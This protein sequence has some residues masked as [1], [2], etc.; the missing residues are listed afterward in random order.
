[1]PNAVSKPNLAKEETLASLLRRPE[2]ADRFKQVLG[3]RAGEF[4]SSVLSVGMSMPDV[5]PI[6]ILQS[7]MKAAALD[8]P[9]EKSLG[10]AWIVPYSDHGNKVAQFQI[11]WKGLVQ[12]ALRTAAYS[13]MN[14]RPINA[15]AFGGYDDIGEP[16]ILWN[17]VDETEP[18]IGYAFAWKLINGF[19]KV[20]YWSKEKVEAHAK[21]YSQAYAKG[22]QTPWKTHFD[23]MAMKTIVKNELS[24]WGIL[25]IQ[26]QRAI[27][28]DQS[29]TDASGTRYPDGNDV[30][31]LNNS[32]PDLIGDETPAKVVTQA[33]EPKPSK[34]ER[35]HKPQPPATEAQTEMQ[36]Q[37]AVVQ[38]IQKPVQP[39]PAPEATAPPPAV[40]VAPPSESATLLAQGIVEMGIPEE[41]FLLWVNNTG[42]FKGADKLAGI[43]DLPAEVCASILADPSGLA[44]CKRIYG[45]K[46]EPTQEASK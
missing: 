45:T 4:T 42:R 25:S 9:V 37:E 10:F 15:E 22:Y 41:D 23:Q 43:A 32:K 14:V 46:T 17:K 16:I 18:A 35:L 12:L 39:V 40:V 38:E 28:M 11:G 8:L 7:A 27:E 36:R 1:M 29:V 13:R 19:T 24:R 20:C 5:D 30:L 6:S 44:K 26:F 31:P 3:E 33:E 2:Y 34:A 21:R